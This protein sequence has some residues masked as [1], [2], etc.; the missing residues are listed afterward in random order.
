[1]LVP[2]LFQE[3]LRADHAT[4]CRNQHLEDRKLLASEHDIATVPVH[5]AS[6]WIESQTSDLSHRWPVVG[7]PAVEGSEAKHQFSE[8]EGLR[9]VVVG[10][11]LEPGGLVVKSVGRGEHQDR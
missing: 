6:E 5:L 10:A 7:S 9:E 2:G 11:K 3:L 8:L 4:I 1:M